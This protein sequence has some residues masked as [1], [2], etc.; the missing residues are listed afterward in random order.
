FPLI[1]FF[2]K[3]LVASELLR[4]ARVNAFA[5]MPHLRTRIVH[6]IFGFNA[7]PG[8][9]QNSRE[10]IAQRHIARR[11]DRQGSGRIGA[12][13]L[14]LHALPYPQIYVAKMFTGLANPL[15]LS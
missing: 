7:I 14:D 13:M 9:A 1:A 6:V 15:D 2:R 12:R 8:G 5:E 11:A 4:I 3:W 10:R